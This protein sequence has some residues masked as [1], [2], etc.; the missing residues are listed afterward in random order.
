VQTSLLLSSSHQRVYDFCID[1]ALANHI[2]TLHQVARHPEICWRTQP[3]KRAGQFMVRFG[4]SFEK[5]P[6]PQGQPYR[7]RL[8]RKES[9]RRGIRRKR[10]A[11]VSYRA[12]HWLLCGDIWITLTFAGGRPSVWRLDWDNEF[13]I[14]AVW[15]NHHLLIEVQRTPITEKRW[16]EKWRK[17]TEW[18]RAQ[19]WDV[20][21]KVVLLD[22]TGQQDS[23][24]CMPKGTVHVKRIEDLP[25]IIQR[26]PGT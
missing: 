10:I 11:G 2:F 6:G 19:P 8:S 9:V 26:S 7:W 23:T 14:Y 17:R 25:R 13:D 4:D 18:Y 5:M 3:V 22:T 12:E 16:V 24:I 1:L 15:G 21:P 20:K